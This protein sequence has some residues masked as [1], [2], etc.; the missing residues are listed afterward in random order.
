MDLLSRRYASPVF[1]IEQMISFGKFSEFI[2][3]LYDFD[4]ET[5]LWDIYLHKIYNKSFEDFKASVVQK[6]SSDITLETT[7]VNSFNLLQ[8]FNPESEVS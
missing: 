2:S 4:N 7:I 3:S 1:I 8:G 5:K 6:Q